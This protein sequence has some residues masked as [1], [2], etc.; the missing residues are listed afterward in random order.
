[1]P[2]GAR[3]AIG[4]TGVLAATGFALASWVVGAITLI[5]VGIALVMLMRRSPSVRP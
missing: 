1:M 2:Y 3:G 4:G 5:L